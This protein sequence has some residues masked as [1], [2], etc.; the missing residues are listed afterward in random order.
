M[1]DKEQWKSISRNGMEQ[2]GKDNGMTGNNGLMDR[3]IMELW[4]NGIK[5][6]FN[7]IFIYK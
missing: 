1:I 6:V 5:R 2:Q 4:Y 7:G 3:N